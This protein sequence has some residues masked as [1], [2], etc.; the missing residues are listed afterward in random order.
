MTCAWISVALSYFISANALSNQG[1]RLNE[2]NN[3]RKG[4]EKLKNGRIE[5]W[6]KIDKLKVYHR[7]LLMIYKGGL[8]K[9]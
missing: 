6:K 9:S 7:D 3:I 8:R 1:L 4:V 5:R 2:E